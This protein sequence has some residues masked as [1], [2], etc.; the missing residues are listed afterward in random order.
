ML[1]NLVRNYPFSS[2]TKV[3]KYV[4]RHIPDVT[5][6]EIKEAL[7]DRPVRNPKIDKRDVRKLMIK[8]FSPTLN[9]WFH[10]LF[11]NSSKGNPR[12]FHLFIG[13]NTRY[14]VAIPVSNKRSTTIFDSIKEFV[15]KYKP[16]KLT[17]DSEPSFSERNVLE[18]LNKNN[19]QTQFVKDGNHSTLG[20]IDRFTRTLR[21]VGAQLPA[22]PLPGV[23]RIFTNDSMQ[24]LIDIYDTSHHSSINCTP[25][26]MF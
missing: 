26:E 8:I 1:S 3:K 18:Y 7:R 24:K 20:L 22:A 16:I 2:F 11:D 15:E 14:A 13:T 9:T 6:D 17:S 19:V 4:Q 12:F 10:D 5:D 23:N 21:D 25:Q